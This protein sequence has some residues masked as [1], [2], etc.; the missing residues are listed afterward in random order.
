MQHE[1]GSST[2]PVEALPELWGG[3]QTQPTHTPL[4]LR[5]CHRYGLNA[6]YP[7]L[8][9]TRRRQHGAQVDARRRIR[10]ARRGCWHA[11]VNTRCVR[12]L[13]IG[14]SKSCGCGC[15]RAMAWSRHE[16]QIAVCALGQPS[17]PAP[18]TA[19]RLESGHWSRFS[20]RH[21]PQGCRRCEVRMA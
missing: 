17:P 19:V 13:I 21:G 14:S 7:K 20:R 9:T 5:L 16:I 2:T 10:D 4:Q 8:S 6:S 11:L 18:P 3:L 1:P 12:T 15:K